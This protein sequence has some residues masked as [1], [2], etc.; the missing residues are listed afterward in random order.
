MLR[1]HGEKLAAMHLLKSKDSFLRALMDSTNQEH[2]KGS[3]N[4][5]L[6]FNVVEVVDTQNQCFSTWGNLH[7]WEIWNLKKG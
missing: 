3:Y 2:L 1:S 4:S 5:V 6:Q 7:F